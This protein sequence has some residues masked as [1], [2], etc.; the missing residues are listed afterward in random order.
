MNPYNSLLSYYLDC[1]PIC[2]VGNS[3]RKSLVTSCCTEMRNQTFLIEGNSLN[4]HR[5]SCVVLIRISSPSFFCLL[6]YMR[7]IEA[8]SKQFSL[9]GC[10]CL[11][12]PSPSNATTR[13]I[14][15]S[16]FSSHRHGESV[17]LISSAHAVVSGVH[18]NHK[19][20]YSSVAACSFELLSR[21]VLKFRRGRR[22][23]GYSQ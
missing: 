10:G 4:S 2:K 1:L 3:I 13:E 17:K 11:H 14:S 8:E 16:D 20:R 6:G 22:Y 15:R 9:Q 5:V 19:K 21:W 7:N 18:F 12:L 23:I